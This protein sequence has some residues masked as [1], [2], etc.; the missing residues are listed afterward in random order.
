MASWNGHLRITATGTRVALEQALLGVLPV[1]FTAL[2]LAWYARHGTLAIDF[3]REYWVVGNRVVNGL[4]PYDRSW[5]D[6]AVG[7]GFPYP[8][9]AGLWFVPLAL[10]PHN[11]ADWVIAVADIGAVMTTLRVLSVRDWRIYGVVLLWAPVV[12]GWQTANITLLLGL[13]IAIA[14]R[15]RDRPVVAGALIGLA[16]STKVVAW[17][18]AIFLLATKRFRACAWALAAGLVCNVLAWTTVGF[19]QIPSYVNLSREVTRMD[20]PRAYN[21]A[22]LMLRAGA[23]L[24]VSLVV[25][26]TAVAVVC[27]LAVDAGRAGRDRSVFALSVAAVLLAAPVIWLHYFAL[28]VL[29]L[30][31]AQPRLGRV[32]A[33]PIALYACPVHDPTSGQLLATLGV[34][35]V[36]ILSVLQSLETTRAPAPWSSGAHRIANRVGLLR[37]PTPARPPQ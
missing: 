20:A 21:L 3:H 17:P 6:L 33:L 35:V 9:S 30:A 28:L 37:T 27:W 19:D 34:A 14:W 26:L 4:S 1:L 31:V 32:W 24:T 16:I 29:P 11:V 36:V 12:S 7:I 8:A 23:S 25:Q 18:I 2:G 5:Q 13:A 10:L 22:D 15:H